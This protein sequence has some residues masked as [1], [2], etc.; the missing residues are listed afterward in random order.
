MC[1]LNGCI[2]E[3]VLSS[4]FFSALLTRPKCTRILGGNGSF[5]WNC[6]RL[7]LISKCTTLVPR[8]TVLETPR[9][10]H[11]AQAQTPAY[12]SD[13]APG[14][15]EAHRGS[16]VLRTFFPTSFT[17]PR[18]HSSVIAHVV[19][20]S[21]PALPPTWGSFNWNCIRWFLVSK[22]TTLVPRM[23]VLETPRRTHRAQAQTP[24]YVSDCAPG[25][26][27]AHRGYTYTT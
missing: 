6:I 18:A 2:S 11:R 27:E 19:G 17:W 25:P 4:L 15:K 9:R 14:P 7:F 1:N 16:H 5:N 12:V 13:C 24:A 22:C 8:M 10:T 21:H 23:T 3:F 26:K 20:S